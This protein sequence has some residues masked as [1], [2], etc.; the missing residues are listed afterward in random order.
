MTADQGNHGPAGRPRSEEARQ[1]VLNAVD[2]LLV[3]I[4]YAAMTMKNIAERAQVSRQ[5]VYRWWS[6]KAEILFEAC[7]EDATDELAIVPSG[8]TVTDIA[9]YLSALIEFLSRS[10]S[11]IAYRALVGEA[12]HSKEVAAL[13][14]TS[15]ILLNSAIEVLE[16][17]TDSSRR[18]ASPET[19]ARLIAPVF[20][21]IFSGKDPKALVA[22]ALADIF[23]SECPA[24]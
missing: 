11:G 17:L 22:T 23:V 1:A 7:A 2:D 5:T 6:T 8:V 13:L 16:G 21:W 15:D 3:E 24:A 14:A 9:A 19:A 20:Y 18:T 4:G 10:P 12:Q